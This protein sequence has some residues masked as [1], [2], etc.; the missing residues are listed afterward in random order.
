VLTG[1]PGAVNTFEQPRNLVPVTSD[2]AAGNAFGYELPPH[3][4]TVFRLKSR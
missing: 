2:F 1:E 4:L 3:S